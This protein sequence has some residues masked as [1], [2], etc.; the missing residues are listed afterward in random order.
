MRNEIIYIE[1]G[2]PERSL[3]LGLATDILG[4]ACLLVLIGIL[5]L[6][7]VVLQG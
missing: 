4:F 5:T 3:G 1:R 7:C 2:K 6:A